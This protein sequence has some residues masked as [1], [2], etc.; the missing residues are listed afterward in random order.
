LLQSPNHIFC[1]CREKRE[2]PAPAQAEREAH[3][4]RSQAQKDP[5]QGHLPGVPGPEDAGGWPE[6]VSRLVRDLEEEQGSPEAEARQ[7]RENE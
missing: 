6:S 2:D 1:T 3:A 4:C 5:A 7:G